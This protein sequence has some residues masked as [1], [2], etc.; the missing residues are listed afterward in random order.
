M[1]LEVVFGYVFEL[2]GESAEES[3]IPG[4]QWAGLVALIVVHRLWGN[5][6]WV[7]RGSGGV[8]WV[9]VCRFGNRRFPWLLRNTQ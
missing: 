2:F 8:Q 3:A 7:C 6:A 4:V 9:S 1:Q 5:W